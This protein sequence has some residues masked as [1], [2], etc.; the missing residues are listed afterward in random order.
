VIIRSIIVAV[1]GMLALAAATTASPVAAAATPV[2]NIIGGTLAPQGA[3]PFEG[4]LQLAEGG[5]PDWHT[6]GVTL[7][8]PWHVETNAHC[9]TNPPANGA[10]AA[11]ASTVFASWLAANGSVPA[12]DRTDP[13]IYHIRLGSVDRLHGGVLRH[14]THI[15]VYPSWAWGVLNAKNEVGDV[16]KL[17]LDRPVW[18][19]I[20]AWIST[21]Q[22][23]AT[24]RAIGW[25][26]D[27]PP[28]T[29]TGPAPEFLNQVDLPV[30][31]AHQCDGLGIGAGELCLGQGK[32]TQCYGDSGSAVTQLRYGRVVVIGSA[33]RISSQNCDVGTAVETSIAYYL[34]WLSHDGGDS[35]LAVAS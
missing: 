21:V 3:F 10:Q 24:A 13:S 29:W 2:P 8:D 15:S 12:V 26:M 34:P 6:C 30:V 14:V 31:D 20:P 11:A 35:N 5:T 33:S 7:I 28:G 1:T 19:P 32:G 4:S 18:W 27:A 25:G 22:P 16:A 23:D 9:V 17:T